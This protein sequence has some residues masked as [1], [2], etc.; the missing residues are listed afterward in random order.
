MK[1]NNNCLKKWGI[2]ILLKENERI[3]DLEY[4]GLKIIQNKNGFCFGIDSV[5]LSDFAKEIKKDSRVL[6]LGTGTGIISIL[7]CGKTNLKEIIGVEI[8]EEVYEMAKRSSE[9]NNLED[10]FKLVNENIKSLSK[11]F[12][13]N[14]F[15][16]IVTNPPYK[17]KNTGLTSEDETNLISRH[18]IMCNIEDIAKQASF[19]LKSNSSI[20]IVHRPDRLADILEALRKYKLEPKNI[21]LIYPKINKEPNL[22]LIK[23]TK[24]GKPFLKMEKPL[25]VYN[26][27]GTY[28]DEILK[29]YGKKE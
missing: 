18:E 22:V 21:R 8:Q 9:L 13:A 3:D 7:L 10:K 29:I 1:I 4:K 6:D 15:D 14:S 20:Y 28:T 17:K 12:P 2:I 11:I 27:D 16:A 19:L 5:L 24:C 23:A 26:E 25:I